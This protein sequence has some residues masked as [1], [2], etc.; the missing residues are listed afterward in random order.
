MG[1]GS[2][3]CQGIVEPGASSRV[4]SDDSLG[5]GK[6]YIRNAGEYFFTEPYEERGGTPVFLGVAFYLCIPPSIEKRLS[7]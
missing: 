4:G 3:L 5:G 6:G 1:R 2:C 7:S